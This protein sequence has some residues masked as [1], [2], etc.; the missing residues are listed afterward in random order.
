MRIDTHLHA[1]ADAAEGEHDLTTYPIVEYGDKDVSFAGVNGTIDDAV[2]ALADAGFDH[3][4]LLGSFELPELPHP[5]GDARH[6]PAQPVYG[7]F[8]DELIAYN[9]WLCDQGA[10]HPVLL[11]FVTANP[12]V[13]TSDESREHLGEAFGS[14]GARGM[15]IHPIAIRTYPDDPGMEGVYDA[16][17]DADA[18]IVFHGGPDKREY[19]W[20]VPGA[21][22]GLAERR[23]GLKV[24]VAHLGGAAWQDTAALA[25]AYPHLM[26]DLSEV[27]IWSGAPLAPSFEQIVALVREIGVERV[28]LGSDFPWYTPGETARIVEEDLPGLSAAEKALILGDNAARLLRLI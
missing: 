6:W 3:A 7:Q 1:Y 9:R 21:F 20:S 11:P 8:R 14:W 15:K 16:L 2:A 18:P 19:G 5:P 17:E 23:P 12:A 13:M 25:A 24:I 28:V 10:A 26:F 4:A 27:V 22:A